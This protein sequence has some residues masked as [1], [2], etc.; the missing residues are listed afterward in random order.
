[1]PVC[2]LCYDAARRDLRDAEYVPMCVACLEILRR[3]VEEGNIVCNDGTRPAAAC[4]ACR[5][6]CCYMRVGDGLPMCWECHGWWKRCA[7]DDAY[8]AASRR[9]CDRLDNM[10]MGHMM[11]P[12][13]R[14]LFTRQIAPPRPPA[15][16][17]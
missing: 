11:P 9:L 17:G 13:A 1:M 6:T 12:L 15:T 2:T 8:V 3:G 4:T 7:G 16:R 5:R 10:G 14:K